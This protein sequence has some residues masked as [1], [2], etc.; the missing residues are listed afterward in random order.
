[1]SHEP[2]QRDPLKS[3]CNDPTLTVPATKG[4]VAQIFTAINAIADKVDTF[5][6]STTTLINGVNSRISTLEKDIADGSMTGGD[7]TDPQSGFSSFLS[8]ATPTDPVSAVTPSHLD[9]GNPPSKHGLDSDEDDHSKDD[10][11]KPK[12]KKLKKHKRDRPSS[13]SSDSDSDTQQMDPY[14]QEIMQE[15]ETT[16]PKYLE[17]PTTAPIQPPLAQMLET[18]FWSVYSSDEVKTE[19]CKPLRPSNASALIPTKIRSNEAIF[20]SLSVQAL[21]KDMPSR[22]IQNAFMKSTQPLAIVWDTLIQLENFLKS[23][24]QSLSFKLSNS[25]SVDFQ[26]L[27]KHMDQALRLLGIANSQMV[28]HRK[29]L[30]S[31]YLN[32]DFKKIC[33]KHIAFDHW[34]FGSNLKALLEDTARVNKL[35]QQNKPSPPSQNTAQKLSFFRKGGGQPGPRNTQQRGKSQFGQGRGFGRGWQVTSSNIQ[36]PPVQNKSGNPQQKQQTKR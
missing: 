33:K 27:R 21:S 8:L 11:K 35:V 18:W 29:D 2:P 34:M 22:F 23:N 6:T 9:T 15:Y 1:M 16:K 31:H 25:F 17:D 10:H 12:R 32:K 30:L 7:L 13:S 20:R 14:M 19:L 28:V 3:D 36:S 4:D 26:V 24:K 5:K